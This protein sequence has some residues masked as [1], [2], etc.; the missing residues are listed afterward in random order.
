VLGQT[1]TDWRAE[2]REAARAEILRTA[3]E[4]AREHGLAGLSLRDLA[5]R[6]GMATPSLYSYFDSKNALYDAMFAQGWQTLLD[7]EQP[8]PGPDLRA[9]LRR[10]TQAYVEWALED[11]VRY[12]LLN[13]RTIPGFE[14]SPTAY[15][16]AERAYAHMTAPLK[17]LADVS[18]EDLDLL[19]ALVGGLI[20]QQIANDPGGTRWVRLVGDAMDLFAHRLEQKRTAPAPA[21]ARRDRRRDT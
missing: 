10:S 20:N 21:A 1:K 4:L 5:R 14:P 15:A 9:Y 16:V 13:Q 6:L 8:Q 12:E 7:V 2:R 18:Q 17:A 19:I 3:N 11:P